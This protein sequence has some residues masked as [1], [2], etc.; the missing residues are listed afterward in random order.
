[1]LAWANNANS[2]RNNLSRRANADETLKDAI[3]ATND[4]QLVAFTITHIRKET[5]TFTAGTGTNDAKYVGYF[6]TYGNDIESTLIPDM[7][8]N[9][10]SGLKLQLANLRTSD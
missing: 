10:I 7:I 5:S 3:R 6:Q 1:M 4:A 9:E 2:N 8:N